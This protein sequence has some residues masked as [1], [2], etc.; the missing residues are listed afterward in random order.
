MKLLLIPILI[1]FTILHSCTSPDNSIKPDEIANA[2]F[3]PIELAGIT[4]MIQFVDSIL[5]DKANT[6]DINQAYHAYFESMETYIEKENTFPDF[7]VVKDSVKF[8]FLESLDKAA[9]DAV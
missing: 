8:K 3:S 7:G 9:I 4:K 5:C 1:A 6:S 2:I